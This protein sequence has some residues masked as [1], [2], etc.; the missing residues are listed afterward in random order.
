[1]S[2]VTVAWYFSLAAQAILA[3][4]LWL[5]HRRDWWVRYLIIALLVSFIRISFS[6]L[7]NGHDYW[8][9]WVATEPL[10]LGLQFL[11]VEQA[12]RGTTRDLLHIAILLAISFTLWAILLTGE[13]WPVLRRASLLLRQAGTFGCFSVLLIPFLARSLPARTDPWML[14]YFTI[15]GISLALAQISPEIQAVRLVSG[16]HL[17]AIA[18]LFLAWSAHAFLLHSRSKTLEYERSGV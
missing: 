8:R 13:H 4:V 14:G 10:L 5:T 1:M 9:A 7:G 3:L 2:V 16:I 6:G 18:I 11:A 17:C 12:T 15:N